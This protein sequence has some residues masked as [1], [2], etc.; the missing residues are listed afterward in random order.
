MQVP[1]RPAGARTLFV[2][3]HA[4]DNW[5]ALRSTRG[6]NRIVSFSSQ[7]CRVPDDIIEQLKQ[8]CSIVTEFT[9]LKPGDK[10]Q[11]KVGPYAQVDA[12]FLALEGKERVMLFLNILHREQAVRVLLQHLM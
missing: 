3:L 5:T 7:P 6:V 8:R 12:I 11:V 9:A 10:V 4:Q 1:S 2:H